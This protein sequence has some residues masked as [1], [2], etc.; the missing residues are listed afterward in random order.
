[1]MTMKV[2]T[3]VI[4]LL[5][6][7]QGLSGSRITFQATPSNIYPVLT[8]TLQL[9]CGVQQNGIVVK[10]QIEALFLPQPTKSADQTSW[11]T[12]PTTAA[13]AASGPTIHG[14]RTNTP[15]S[16][17]VGL[18]HIISIIVSRSDKTT[19]LQEKVASLSTFDP[20]TAYV[21]LDKITVDGYSDSSSIA[22]ELGYLEITWAYPVSHQAGNYTCEVYAVDSTLRP[23]STSEA[24]YITASEPTITEL[25]S[26]IAQNNNYITE[27]RQTVLELRNQTSHLQTQSQENALAMKNISQGVYR[28][29][30]NSLIIQTGN[31]TCQNYYETV[32]N[33][34]FERS[35]NNIPTV[36]IA[37]NG[38]TI[39]S[40]PGTSNVTIHDVTKTSFYIYCDSND[41]Y[42]NHPLVIKADWIAIGS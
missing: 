29:E 20:P 24:V 18:S 42:Y 22:G 10:K 34:Q 26:I 4:F 9:R 25:A 28:N 37:V 15:K 6:F 7:C 13:A 12:T 2:P 23:V 14:P 41:N 39:N 36:F 16:T 30:T 17:Q 8:K 27:L 11:L 31:V 5:L 40:Y 21:D 32:T 1:M 35:Y 38:V 19:G 3:C 33:V